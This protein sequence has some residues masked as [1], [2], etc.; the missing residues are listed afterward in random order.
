MRILPIN[1]IDLV[2][3]RVLEV[4]HISN[5]WLTPV[6]SK[7]DTIGDGTLKIFSISRS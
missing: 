7:F 2:Q 5:R 1:L 3:Q 4:K 6:H